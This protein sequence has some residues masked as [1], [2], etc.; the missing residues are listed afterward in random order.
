LN[1]FAAVMPGIREVRTPLS[2]GGLWLCFLYLL[3]APKWSDY[4][5]GH[6]GGAAWLLSAIAAVPTAY[7]VGGLAFAA[8]LM[9][10]AVQPIS[11]TL[12]KL[13][14]RPLYIA[15]ERRYTPPGKVQRA[16]FNW[17]RARLKV[18][19]YLS[20]I[21][22]A[23]TST[24]VRAGLPA[25]MALHYPNELVL[26]RLDATA[27]QLWKA[28]ADQYQEYDR[29]R[30]ERDFRR[31][32][33]LPLIAVGCPL[34]WLLGWWLS[35][36]VAIGAF[37]LLYQCWGLDHRRKVLIANALFQHLAEDAELKAMVAIL[38]TLDLPTGWR[39]KE[40][41][42][43]AVTAVAFSKLGDFESSDD[44]TWESAAAVVND[45]RQDT[46]E[47]DPLAVD[48]LAAEVRVV[49]SMNDEKDAIPVFDARM[50]KHREELAATANVG[51]AS[52]EQAT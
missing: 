37:V 41:L 31:G 26:N 43:C 40:S 33:W 1:L 47:I 32:V 23:V 6:T 38:A 19:E 42:R 44:L 24:Y 2:V 3:L 10:I 13:V 8:Y 12:G 7:L 35:P 34:G 28:N 15:Q 29:L 20:P 49:F 9:G 30:A 4:S 22:D 50:E 5:N 11:V 48:A 18:S 36:L 46:S 39:E 52:L 25:S 45:V 17:V 21:T 51:A 27:L 16:V 14:L